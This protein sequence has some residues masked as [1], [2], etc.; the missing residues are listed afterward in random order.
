MI[1][2]V[3]IFEGW[4]I[5]A[6]HLK[7]SQLLCSRCAG[8]NDNDDNNVGHMLI[9]MAIILPTGQWYAPSEVC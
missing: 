1:E 9:K 4:L 7:Y 6:T 5:A 8:H 3:L 2:M